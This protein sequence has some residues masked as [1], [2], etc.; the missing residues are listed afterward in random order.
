MKRL[1]LPENYESKLSLLETEIAIKF[2]KDTFEKDL[3]NKLHLVRVS[4]PLFVFPKS[5]LNDN[6]NG[7]ERRVNFDIKIFLMRLR[8]FNL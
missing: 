5:G 8:L 1:I 3:A 4:A 2:V 7:Y 6:L